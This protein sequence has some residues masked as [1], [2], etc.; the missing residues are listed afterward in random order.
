MSDPPTASGRARLRRVQRAACALRVSNIELPMDFQ[1]ELPEVSADPH[2]SATG[3]LST[4]TG[5]H[6][7]HVK[8]EPR[9]RDAM[10]MQFL[11]DR[12]RGEGH[13]AKERTIADA[14]AA[15]T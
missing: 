3:L 6:L 13:Q 14:G 8:K 10:D 12:P 1:A 9:L 5:G 2:Q 7:G 11:E 15:R 4:G